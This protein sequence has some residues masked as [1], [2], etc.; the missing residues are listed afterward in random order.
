MNHKLYIIEGL[1]CSGKSTTAA[2]VA[3]LLKAEHPVCFVDEGSGEHPADHEFHAF[4][5]ETELSDFTAG[6][7]DTI[8]SCA[9]LM[10]DGYIVPLARFEGALFE[11]LL[12]HKI[13]DFLPWATEMPVMLAKWQNFCKQAVKTDTV[14]VFNC[15]LLQNPMCE[16]MMRF[17]FTLEQSQ[18]YISEIA[19][20]IQPLHPAVIY[21]KN[22]D[23]QASVEK[24]A[25]ERE[26]WLDAV[27]DYHVNG[28]YGKSISAEG[29]DGYIRCLEERQRREL[30]IL[31]AL[32][33][34]SHVIE[35][36]QR[37][38]DNAYDTIIK[39]ATSE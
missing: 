33:V 15:V 28:A 34:T 25:K 6:E 10:Q 11:R 7:Q 12:P 21:L 30:E 27:I 4:I 5:T 23:I 38:W 26:G 8:R 35:N 13:Y 24:A 39:W 2:F 36:P 14:Y 32:P 20:S 37:D 31:S 1:P 19:K 3:D 18:A 9:E 16:T 29:F 22:D 17:G